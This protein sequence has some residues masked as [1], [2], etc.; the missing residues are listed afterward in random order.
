[1]C[2][3]HNCH[4]GLLNSTITGSE[5]HQIAHMTLSGYLTIR[6]TKNLTLTANTTLSLIKCQHTLAV[7]FTF[8]NLS[9]NTQKKAISIHI[10]ATSWLPSVHND[11]WTIAVQLNVN[12]FPHFSTMPRN[13]TLPASKQSC[14]PI[15]HQKSYRNNLTSS[16][17]RRVFRWRRLLIG[18]L[19]HTWHTQAGIHRR[20]NFAHNIPYVAIHCVRHSDRRPNI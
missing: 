9:N 13:H 10:L 14:W 2:G 6:F 16:N 15:I 17:L 5:N 8:M 11:E 4:C 1:M 18:D 7:G 3:W 19:S 20:F 12:I